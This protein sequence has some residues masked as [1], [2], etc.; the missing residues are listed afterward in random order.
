MEK[1][2]DNSK[3]PSR[4]QLHRIMKMPEKEKK[5]ASE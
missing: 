2:I 4:H 1:S 5:K 3:C